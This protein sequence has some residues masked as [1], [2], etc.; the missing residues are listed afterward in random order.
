MTSELFVGERFQMLRSQ[1]SCFYAM[2]WLEQNFPFKDG[3]EDSPRLLLS[4]IDLYTR[5]E[6]ED[7]LYLRIGFF[8]TNCAFHSQ[9]KMEN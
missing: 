5:G 9:E 7:K 2:P 3:V 8:Q 4:A 6:R 1:S